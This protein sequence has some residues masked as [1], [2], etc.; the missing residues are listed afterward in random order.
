MEEYG[1]P[2]F[3]GALDVAGRGKADLVL[4]PEY[5][6]GEIVTEPL[7]GPSAALMSSKAREYGMYVA[8]TI[9]REDKAAGR[10]Y[11]TALLFGRDGKPV[12]SYDKIHL[13]GPELKREG[14]TPGS[15][16]PVF[17][18]DFGRVGFMTCCDVSFTDVV[19]LLALKGA[20]MV[21]FP[22][23]GYD[24]GLMRVRALDNL[25]NIVASSRSGSYGVW[26]AAGRDALSST[27]LAAGS[28]AFRDVVETMSGTLG[29]LIV[30]VDLNAVLPPETAAGVRF[31]VARSRRQFGNQR[32]WLEEEILREKQR[33][34]AE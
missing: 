11:N 1:L 2:V 25:V 24:R 19:E 28:P 17:Q 27:T 31:P 29:I 13:Y 12:G 5:M 14:V 8:G 30:S 21:L 33:W 23:L 32:V 20:D 16:V 3:R 10:L 26:D 22:N 15:R 7:D 18:A 4:L 34:W 9:A 6:N